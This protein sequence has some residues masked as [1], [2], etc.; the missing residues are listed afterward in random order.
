VFYVE[1]LESVEQGRSSVK[2]AFVLY[3][4][5]FGASLAYITAKP[6]VEEEREINMVEIQRP[7]YDVM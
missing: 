3:C 2:G 4:C 5:T 7:E 6:E 1:G